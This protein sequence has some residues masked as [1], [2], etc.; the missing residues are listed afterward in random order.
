VVAGVGVES[1]EQLEVP[2][3]HRRLA[4]VTKKST[5][6]VP[7]G[8]MGQIWVSVGTE[9][10]DASVTAVADARSAWTLAVRAW[11]VTLESLGHV[12]S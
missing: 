11:K 12:V 7:F 6:Q 5:G 1:R 4:R 10:A 3:V 9:W 2:V 8:A